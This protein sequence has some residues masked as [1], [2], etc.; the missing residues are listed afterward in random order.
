MEK[1]PVLVAGM[2]G[3]SLGSEIIKSLNLAKNKYQIYGCDLSPLAYGHYMEG[4]HASYVID[5]ENYVENVIKIC[6]K[7]DISVVV[8]GGD[9]PAVLLGGA[10]DILEENGLLFAGN[11]SSVV[12]VCSHKGHLFEYLAGHDIV[13]PQSWTI[14]AIEDIE[15]IHTFPC[16]IKPATNSGG[17][18]SVFITQNSDELRIYAAYML[19]NNMIPIVQEYLPH[20]TGE[21]TVGV[22][23]SPEG[24]LVGSIALKRLF[25]AKVSIMSKTD[26][27]LISSGY[28]QGEIHDFPEIR[29]TAEKI[30]SLCGSMGPLNIQGRLKDGVFCP[31]EI[32]PRLSASTYLRALAGFNEIDM[33]IDMLL[34][35]EV[36]THPNIKYGYYLRSF[37]EK[38]VS[39]QEVRK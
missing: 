18:T 38:H 26:S 19:N 10:K 8:P 2:A 34:G 21:F 11:T 35:N 32:N 14:H 12:N 6:K 28:S 30:A 4:V 24:K 25:H 20:E 5:R 1:T 31:F 3:A 9:E 27:G 39:Y 13:I 15:S 22:L 37:E 17:S 16:I 7:E 29:E 33:Y 36:E 23:H